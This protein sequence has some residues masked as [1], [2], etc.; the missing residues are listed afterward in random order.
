MKPWTRHLDILD[1][2]FLSEKDDDTIE[3]LSG[4]M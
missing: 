3:C 1:L 2:I 4:L